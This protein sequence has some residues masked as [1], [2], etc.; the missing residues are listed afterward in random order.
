MSIETDIKTILDDYS[1]L[2][3]LVS[4]RNYIIK[5]PQNPATPY[6]VLSY[7][8]EIQNNVSGESSLEKVELQV[9]VRADTY[10]E[11]RSVAIQVKAAMAAA[12]TV[13]SY[14]ITD[15]DVNF[16]DQVDTYRT[17]LRFSVW[18]Y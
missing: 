13:Q 11:T 12:T 18:Q 1:A 14:C 6:N 5:S 10:A 7:N 15:E 3:S 2:S 9:D 4:T 8:R 16:E 17:V